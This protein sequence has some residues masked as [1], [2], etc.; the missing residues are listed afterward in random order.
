[1]K[2]RQVTQGFSKVLL[3]LL[4]IV[5]IGS[6]HAQTLDDVLGVRASTTQDGRASQRRIDE[7]SEQTRGLLTQY[8]QVMKIVDG[9][10]VYNEQQER[11]IKVQEKELRELEESIDN[12]TVIERQM[13]PLIERMIAN[14]DKF[15]ELDVP[16]LSNERSERID[17]LKAT[18]DRADVS[19]AEKFSQVLQAYQVENAYGSTLDVYTEVIAID[20]VDRQVEMLKWG[21]VA[22]VF[23]TLD[24]ET[25]GVWDKN[26]NDWEILDN[27]YRLGVR[28]GFRIAKKTQTADFV[29]LPIPAAGVK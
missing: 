21:R 25:T 11:L 24:G 8:K 3:C 19:V 23:Q 14:L 12:V 28:N 1:M 18:F 20:G 10:R 17:F 13:G 4:S 26:I 5:L 22:L 7:I 16:F 6:A 29:H 15:V 2:D 9:L 27:E